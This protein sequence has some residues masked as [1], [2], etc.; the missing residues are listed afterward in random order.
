MPRRRPNAA[1]LLVALA[2]APGQP[3]AGPDEGGDARLRAWNPAYADVCLLPGAES[4]PAEGLAAI[5]EA[6]SGPDAFSRH[7][8]EVAEAAEVVF[9]IDPRLAD[10]R[11]YYEPASRVVALDPGL[12][13]AEMV[14]IAVHELR[15]ADQFRRG[16]APSLDISRSETARLTYALEADA[17]AI[18]TLYA[19]R[20]SRARDGRG[21]WEAAQT[22]EHYED[23]ATAFAAA[24][25]GGDDAAGARAAFAR[26]YASDWRREKYYLS[27]CGA[28]L[29]QLDAAHAIVRYDPLPEGYFD[30]FCVLPEGGDYGCHLTEEIARPPRDWE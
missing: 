22:L 30:G 15:H 9:C 14:L 24:A 8:A 3:L 19:W 26:W 20:A 18:T 29:D 1:L 5:S 7:L 11:G 4:G 10:C 28:W 2:L 27:A 21:L 16:F 6:L 25:S 23:L 12:S 17:Q 13:P